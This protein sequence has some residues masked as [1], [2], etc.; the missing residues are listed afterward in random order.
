MIVVHLPSGLRAEFGSQL[1][2][3]RPVATIGALVAALEDLRP[4]LSEHLHDSLYNFAVNDT[5]ILHGTDAH[6]LHDGDIVELIP[7]IA[8]G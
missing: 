8:G 1:S 3:D 5:L 2:V 4:G 6:P 7:T